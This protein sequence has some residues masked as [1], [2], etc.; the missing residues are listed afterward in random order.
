MSEN[1]FAVQ[2]RIARFANMLDLKDWQAVQ[3]CFTEMVYSDYSDLRGTPPETIP[4]GEYVRRRHEALTPIRVHH[5]VSNFETD[6]PDEKSA[7]CRASMVIW[8]KT[9]EDE[10]ST[11]CVYTFQLT[12]QGAEWKI[13]GVTQ[14]VLWNDGNPS[15]HTGAAKA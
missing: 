3:D 9:D 12:R 4:A 2:E 1:K 10:F 8:R 6:F 11:H 13:N 5:L 7:T 15:I 14:K